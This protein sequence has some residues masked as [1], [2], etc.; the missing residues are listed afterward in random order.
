MSGKHAQFDE[1]ALNGSPITEK[2]MQKAYAFE[3][4]N[5]GFSSD[6]YVT[7]WSLRHQQIT[8]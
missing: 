3:E 5:P 8:A 6:N 4:N 2:A 7:E 1:V